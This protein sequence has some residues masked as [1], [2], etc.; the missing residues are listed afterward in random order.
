M[1]ALDHKNVVKLYNHFEEQNAVYLIMELI[2]GGEIYA[3]MTHSMTKK[4]TEN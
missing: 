1:Y 3:K 4:F 2:T